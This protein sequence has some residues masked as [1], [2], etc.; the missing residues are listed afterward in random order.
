MKQDNNVG[1]KGTGQVLDS[2]AGRESGEVEGRRRVRH[3]G[4][5]PP[6]QAGQGLDAERT[7]LHRLM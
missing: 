1:E 6:R 7:R 3:S 2:E 4:P 5:Y